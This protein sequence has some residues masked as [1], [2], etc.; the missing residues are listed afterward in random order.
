MA[1]LRY[2][3]YLQKCPVGSY[4]SKSRVYVVCQVKIHA[5]KRAACIQYAKSRNWMRND[6]EKEHQQRRQFRDEA[7]N[8]RGQR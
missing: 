8:N 4:M 7:W 1:Y 5:Y 2:L 3:F 6:L